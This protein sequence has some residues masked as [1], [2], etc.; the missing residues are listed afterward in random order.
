MSFAKAQIFSW[1]NPNYRSRAIVAQ[2]SV[3]LDSLF[4]LQEGF[5]ILDQQ[6]DLIPKSLYRIDFEKSMLYLNPEV[7]DSLR[8]SYYVH[9]TLKKQTTY[10]KDPKL[11]VAS[12]S[13]VDAVVLS[14]IT[15]EKKEIF[16]G[17]ATQ[18]SMVR[19]ITMGNNQ[20]SSAQSSLDLRMNGQLSPEVGITAVISDTNVPIEADGYTQNLDQ[21]DK[22]YVELFTDQS[23][24][25][26]GHVDL[27]QTE[28]YFGRFNRRVS[29]LQLNHMISSENSATHFDVAGSISRGE[30]KQMSFKGQEGN[31]GPYRL[32]GNYDESYVT[33]LSGSERVYKDGVLLQRGENYDYVINYN[34]GEITFTN[35]HM[36]RSTDRFIA[37]YQYTNRY[38]N[39]FLLYGGA[40]HVGERFSISAHTYSESDSKNNAINQN[41]SAEDKAIL[42]QAGND[43][44]AM[45]ADAYEEVPFEEGKILYKKT[46]LNGE[47]IFEY[48]NTSEE[49]V[50]NV[51]FTYLGENNGNYI[52]SDNRV[53]GRVFSYVPPQNG[54][55]QGHYEPIRLLVAPQKNQVLSLASSY[56]L[57]NDGRINL[58]VGVSNVDKNLFSDLDDT[59]NVGYALKLGGEKKI[60]KGKWT[61]TPQVNYEYIN[62]N[63]SS[64]ER[65]RSPEFVR[66]FNLTQEIGGGNQQFLQS[67]MLVA[68]SDSIYA[69]YG[70]DYL[71][72]ASQYNGTRHRIN[73]QYLTPKT[74]MLA[75]YKMMQSKA[76]AEESKFDEYRFSAGRQ[77]GNL[78]LMAGVLG[79]RNKRSLNEQ[80]DTLSFAW[81]EVYGAAMLGDTIG[82][83]AYVK[84]Y[85]RQNDSIQL[86]RFQRNSEAVGMEFN[87][88]IIKNETQALRFLSHYRRI[89]Y[90]DSID[91]VSFLNATIDWRKSLWNRAIEM[92]ANYQISGGT[93][94]QRAF[95]YVKVA[96]G[97]GIYKWTD[98]NNDGVQQLDEFEV[99][100]FSDE[101]NFVRVY[102]NSVD[103]IRTNKNALNISL[104]LNPSRY[105]GNESFWRRIQSTL[106]YTTEG[107]FLKKDKTAHLNPWQ[108]NQS[109]RYKNLQFYMQNKYNTGKQYR[110]SFVHELSVQENTR[111]VFTGLE[112]LSTK[113]NKFSL[114][115]HW[116]DFV[117]AELTQE[118]K[119]ID[120]DSEAFESKTFNVYGTEWIPKLYFKHTEEF[121]YSLAYKYQDYVNEISIESLQAHQLNFDFVWNDQQKT[122]VLAGLDW[123][124]N[125]FE[126]NANSVVGNR[127]MEG[128]KD[129]SNLV[130]RLLLQRNLNNYLELNVQYSGRKNQGIHAI[131]TGNVQI[132]LNF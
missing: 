127:M 72:N 73:A 14:N 5:E 109:V 113:L 100:E 62:Q 1:E 50:Y 66:E 120:S 75:V 17:I 47:E 15:E 56:K 63:F 89:N 106:S 115:R 83:Y 26:A 65:L 130:W 117:T 41:L 42:A 76:V 97:M 33:V 99:A 126:G 80:I 107:N 101:A 85:Q 131:H 9:P 8:V 74:E 53:N 39:R 16:D 108:K 55:K 23:K 93:E 68:L 88:Q 86:G 114:Q 2:D 32:K 45:Y 124:K 122:S 82:K 96:D 128:L 51:N 30:F 52:L 77:L 46:M 69:N 110:W 79:E 11:I 21:F 19:G 90:A 70:F 129:G 121:K 37:E 91:K 35:K 78:K 61:I 13:E 43:E 111:F 118:T 116:S 6:G 98:Y 64:L 102:T 58:D 123:V 105:F 54:V 12:P 112:N 95:T 10:P 94:L 67:N 24:A 22:V 3:V 25:R 71:N 104:R 34:T 49:P 28:E 87:A 29:G 4:I 44:E 18:G 7:Q 125:K 84:L 31:Q 92:S 103:Q 36:V 40:K 81:N 60:T 38:Y 132:R 119:W 20:G 27:A 59:Q 57:K 48:T